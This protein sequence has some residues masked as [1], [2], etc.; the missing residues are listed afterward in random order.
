MRGFYDC[1]LSTGEQRQLGYIREVGKKNMKHQDNILV[2]VIYSF[3]PGRTTNT[4]PKDSKT[5]VP[6]MESSYSQCSPCWSDEQPSPP[7][8]HC[9]QT[10]L[11]SPTEVSLPLSNSLSHSPLHTNNSSALHS[12]QRRGVRLKVK[13]KKSTIRMYAC[14]DYWYNLNLLHG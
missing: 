9:T 8:L 14:P 2:F 7:Q 4:T 1:T 10:C 3:L 13:G 6:G 11:R 5:D 12:H